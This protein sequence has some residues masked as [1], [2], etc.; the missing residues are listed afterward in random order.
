[1]LIDKCI[2]HFS[3]WWL[4]GVKD[5]ASWGWELQDLSNQYVMYAETGGL[6]TLLLFIGIISRSFGS[7]GTARRLAEGDPK[8]EWLLWCLCAALFADVMAYFGIAYFDQTQFVW[9]ALLAIISSEI[10]GAS[11]VSAAQVPA[12]A[13]S[14]WRVNPSMNWELLDP[15]H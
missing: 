12:T 2:Q 9:Y 3:D 10:V 8:N 11:R 14:K 6:F 4:L 1:L 13:P 7:L 5:F 15:N